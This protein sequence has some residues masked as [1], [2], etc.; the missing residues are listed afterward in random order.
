M[1]LRHTFLFILPLLAFSSTALSSQSRGCQIKQANLEKQL[2][3]AKHYG[4]HWR[5][6][7]LQRAIS[8]VKAHCTGAGL[9]ASN[10][11]DIKDKREDIAELQEDV[12]EARAKGDTKK[13][14]KKLRKLQEAQAELA[15]MQQNVY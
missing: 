4:N 13:V 14:N 2:S 1:S 15:E 5:V 11:K 8:N 3:Y 7:G 12:Q 9:A 6:A 10:A